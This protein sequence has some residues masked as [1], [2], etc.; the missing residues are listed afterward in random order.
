MRIAGKRKTPLPAWAWR[1]QQRDLERG[2][3]IVSLRQRGYTWADLVD[4]FG[5]GDH[6]EARKLAVHY[7]LASAGPRE[8]AQEGA[9]DAQAATAAD[10]SPEDER[11]G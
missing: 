8:A 2:G 4:A 7:L 3:A 6:Y 1:R 10:R 11:A 5:L 9:G